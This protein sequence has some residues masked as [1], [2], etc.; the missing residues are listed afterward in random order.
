MKENGDIKICDCGNPLIWTFII[1]Y[2]EWF[3]W[4][5]KGSLPMLNARRV[6]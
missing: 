4:D 5:C 2:A 6:P 1:P 3:C